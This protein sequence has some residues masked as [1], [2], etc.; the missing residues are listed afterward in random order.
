MPRPT[1]PAGTMRPRWRSARERQKRGPTGRSWPVAARVRRGNRR[2]SDPR[3][4]PCYPGRAGIY[5]RTGVAGTVFAPSVKSARDEMAGS[6]DRQVHARN[7]PGAARV[8]IAVIGAGPA[9]L[10]AAIALASAGIETALV[11]K[12]PARPDN[13]TTALLA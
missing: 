9:G 8:E 4:R 2:E 12:R 1:T 7:G 13:R 11:S 10:T 3:S 5:A 6:S